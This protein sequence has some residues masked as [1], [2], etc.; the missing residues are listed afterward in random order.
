MFSSLWIRGFTA[1]VVCASA[2][3]VPA[4][5]AVC[6]G[7]HQVGNTSLKSV[8]VAS[9]LT[10]RPLFV[11][12]PRGD[13]DRL[14]I[15]GQNGIISIHRRGDPA[16]V[17][18]TFLNISS[19][20][21]ASF[22][23]ECGLLGM[24]FDPNYATNRHVFVSY[25][26]NVGGDVYSVVARYVTSASNPDLIDTAIP[27][28]RLVRFLQPETNHN[29]GWIAF[30]PDNYLYVATGDGG[31]A[32]DS[33]GSCG[34]G[35]SNTTLLGKILR[36]D[37][38][39]QPQNR[40]ADCG[41]TTNYRVPADNPLVGG[42]STNCE[43]IWASGLRNPWRPSIDPLNGDWYIADVGQNCWEEV[44]WVPAA[45]AKGRN[46]G[47]REM[48]GK[49]CF[50]ILQSTVCNPTP[51]TG[52]PKT[53]N[54]P[55]FT[56]PVI[57][58]DHG[59]GCSVTGG[60]VYR[61]CQMTGFQGVYFYGDYCEG[62]VKSF[63]IAGGLPTQQSDWS[64]V[65]DPNG[66]LVGGLTSFGTDGQG[67]LYVTDRNGDVRRIMPPFSDLEVSGDGVLPSNRFLLGKPNWTWENLARSTMHPVTQYRIY[68]STQPNGS[69]TC[70][71][72]T[73]ATSWTG[74]TT[75]PT[76]AGGLFYLVVAQSPDGELTKPT[77]TPKVLSPSPCP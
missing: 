32:N 18:S 21:N 33:H 22:C 36:I 9:G 48:E 55:S 2:F 16:S 35:Q 67:E 71:Y 13:V 62:W 12:A 8:V 66:D 46:Y 56:Q 3:S 72:K 25:T 6:D 65:I 45:S 37:P 54:D 41:G 14:F 52:C 75:K 23:D 10:A 47:W 53:C 44:N 26:E 68:R 58:Y 30:G 39:S 4:L 49:H 29:G 42:P 76:V 38:A 5:A 20:V 59:V 73:T 70:I 17:N 64:S 34:N 31:G 50:N 7:V 1:L 74:D 51:S 57:D 11:T 24:A 63:R 43:E 60:F 69:F 77:G 19:R 40:A 61:G 15:V 27:E 28:V